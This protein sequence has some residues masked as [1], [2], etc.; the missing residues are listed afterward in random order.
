MELRPLA[1]E[2]RGTLDRWLD[3]EA[4]RFLEDGWPSLG[5]PTDHPSTHAVIG[6]DAGVP[7]GAALFYF[8]EDD[9]AYVSFLVAP[10]ARGRG[11]GRRLL[12]SALAET[13]AS[14]IK[15]DVL[16]ENA[17]SA[18]ALL[19]AGFTE[20]APPADH[21]RGDSDGRFFVWTRSVPPY[22][23]SWV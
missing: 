6:L 16:I 15:A 10:E 11:V 19:A 4:L 8:Y 13:T 23:A 5:S 14:I 3:A 12:R 17:A 20:M 1:A 9:E 2:D 22:E 18:I 21:P 7:V